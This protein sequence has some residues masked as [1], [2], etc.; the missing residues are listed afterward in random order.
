MC[1]MQ[2]RQSIDGLERSQDPNDSTVPRLVL[3]RKCAT[4]DLVPTVERGYWLCFVTGSST[5]GRDC[6]I[7][8]SISTAA[9]IS[10][11]SQFRVS[12]SVQGFVEH[13]LYTTSTYD[14]IRAPTFLD[15]S[16]LDLLA[17]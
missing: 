5:S 12:M 2:A 8:T 9:C 7:P 13:F 1:G 15:I 4:R 11:T 17:N 16:T 10:V 14:K 6:N 3:E